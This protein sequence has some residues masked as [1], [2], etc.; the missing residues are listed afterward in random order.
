MHVAVELAIC[1][2]ASRYWAM[3][4]SVAD[5]VPA[6]IGL[7]AWKTSRQV[8]KSIQLFTIKLSIMARSA[9]RVWAFPAQIIII[10]KFLM[11]KPRDDRFHRPDGRINSLTVGISK[12]DWLRSSNMGSMLDVAEYALKR[13]LSYVGQ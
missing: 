11:S 5:W 9:A 8:S 12:D 7:S 10:A 1:L 6:G 13:A 3:V 4:T 2:V